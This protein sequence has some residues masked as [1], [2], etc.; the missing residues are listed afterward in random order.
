MSIINEYY[1]D[2]A[3]YGK[4]VMTYCEYHG[5]NDYHN[6]CDLLKYI[7][8]DSVVFDIGF[9]IGLFSRIICKN[10]KYHSIHGFEPVKKYFDISKEIIGI[11]PNVKINNVGLSNKEENLTIY[12][13]ENSIGWNSFLLKDPNQ[14]KGLLPIENLSPEI[15]KVI[16]LDS[17]CQENNI[18]K[19]DFVKIDVEGFECKVL[20]GFLG[21][22][23]KLEKKPYF[24]IEVGWGVN[25]P[26]W[27]YC[28]TI[29][30]KLFEIGYT[31]VDFTEKTKDILFVPI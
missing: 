2:Y 25:H 31:K 19:I 17:Y 5:K 24:Y 28:E 27:S 16:T 18:D 21:T 23:S 14:P 12:K 30:N 3:K 4:D 20:D 22:L 6:H 10:G 29:Y 15:C 1:E 7:N 26:E 8:E 13:C 11:Y 9:N